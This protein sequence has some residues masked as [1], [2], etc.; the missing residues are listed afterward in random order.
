MPFNDNNCLDVRNGDWEQ[1]T[2][3]SRDMVKE[4]EYIRDFGLRA[5]Y[6]NWSYQKNSYFK[7]EEYANDR[8]EWV[9]PLGGKRESYRVVGD[10]IITQQDLEEQRTL[11]DGTACMSWNIDMHFPEPDNVAE[12]GE[13]FRS[14]AYHRG[15]GKPFQV[16][17]RALYAKD[18]NNLFLG[19]RILSTSHVAFS[20]IRVMRTLGQLGE[21]VGIAAGICKKHDCKPREI[22]T[23]Y[24]DELKEGLEKGV[25]I[26]TAFGAGVDY[27]E[28]YHFKDIGWLELNPYSCD[29]QYLEKFKRNVK[30]LNLTHKYPLPDKLK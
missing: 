25:A 21:V 27:R 10:Y 12:F 22:Y 11:E 26:P 14:F 7:K 3:F 23:T 30:A 29:E 17:Y 28:S 9:S 4:I 18:V 20:S 16:P 15:Y 24:L 5:I 1:E 13:P 2:G 6:S 19:G 8:L